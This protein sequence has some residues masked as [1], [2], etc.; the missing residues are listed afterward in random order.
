MLA[1]TDGLQPLIFG[2]VE[3]GNNLLDLVNAIGAIQ[4]L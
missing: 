3:L 4:Q 1:F 2:S